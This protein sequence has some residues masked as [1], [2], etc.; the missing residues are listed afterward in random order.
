MWYHSRCIIY[1]VPDTRYNK[2]DNCIRVSFFKS[3]WL[4]KTRLY[5]FIL[6]QIKSH[7]N[8][9]DYPWSSPLDSTVINCIQYK[10]GF[11]LIQNLLPTKVL[12]HNLRIWWKVFFW[13]NLLLT[14]L[15]NVCQCLWKVSTFS[16]CKFILW[17]EGKEEG[18]SQNK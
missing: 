8:E 7:L 18:R 15:W 11:S 9:I 3:Q 6:V 1:E 13:K 14:L 5:Y 12:V 16:Q 2:I 4:A 17:K 10:I